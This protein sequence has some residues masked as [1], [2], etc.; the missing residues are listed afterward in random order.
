[1]VF[2]FISFHLDHSSC[3]WCFSDWVHIQQVPFACIFICISTIPI[4]YILSIRICRICLNFAILT[5]AAQ[6]Q[7]HSVIYPISSRFPGQVHRLQDSKY[8]GILRCEIPDSVGGIS[9]RPSTVLILWAGALPRFDLQVGLLGSVMGS[10]LSSCLHYH[11]N[12]LYYPLRLWW[13]VVCAGHIRTQ[14]VIWYMLGPK[15]RVI[16][17][18]TWLYKKMRQRK[19]TAR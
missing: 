19:I 6:F 11:H 17:K 18:N 8:G 14:E 1:M 12:R 15:E 7:F 2:H 13:N 5:F 10:W 9:S 4:Y 3:K 16:L